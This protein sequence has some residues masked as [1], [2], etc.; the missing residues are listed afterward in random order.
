[1]LHGASRLTWIVELP[2]ALDVHAA[3][4]APPA[5]ATTG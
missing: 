2:D 4:V 3:I 1:L 5:A